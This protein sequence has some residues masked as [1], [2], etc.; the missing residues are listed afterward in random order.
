MINDNDKQTN[1]SDISLDEQI[2]RIVECI[3]PI[4]LSQYHEVMKED[5]E[6]K[7]RQIQQDMD[8]AATNLPQGHSGKTS[9]YGA[10]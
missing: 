3:R 5:Q 9:N 10:V 2:D 4:I 8:G 6:A 1:C 7:Q